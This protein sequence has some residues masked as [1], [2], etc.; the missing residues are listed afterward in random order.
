MTITTK[1]SIGDSVWVMKDDQPQCFAIF[2]IVASVQTDMNAFVG[3]L[4]I[5]ML[6]RYLSEDGEF[7]FFERG[8]Y[9]SREE[10]LASL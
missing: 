3:S 1:F 6:I 7:D 8:C 5:Y 2:K 9:A 4:P 10:L